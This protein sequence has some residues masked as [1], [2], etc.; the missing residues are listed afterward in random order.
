MI[1]LASGLDLREV[2]V[3]GYSKAGLDDVKVFF[4]QASSVYDYLTPVKQE[5][6]LS[7]RAFIKLK[8]NSLFSSP[9]TLCKNALVAV[10]IENYLRKKAEG[11][12]IPVIFCFSSY[13]CPSLPVVR[14]VNKN[15][16][17]S[18]LGE[19]SNS[20]IRRIYKLCNDPK[21]PLEVRQVAEETFRFVHLMKED[22][23]V[24]IREISPPWKK[25][26]DT[27]M[28][29]QELKK[30]TEVKSK[31]NVE[32]KLD[33]RLLLQDPYKA[34]EIIERKERERSSFDVLCEQV[35]KVIGLTRIPELTFF[36]VIGLILLLN[37][38]DESK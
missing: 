2:V 38:C 1:S 16:N 26:S 31:T 24:D 17:S 7:G 25:D 28:R 15:L 3:Y 32:N 29:A 10:V 37:N 35:A 22:L 20:E 13:K 19:V 8:Y 33:W 5:K 4:S 27:W 23:K 12:I 18:K 9:R 14:I 30:S 6:T 21:I 34:H 36:I 11:S